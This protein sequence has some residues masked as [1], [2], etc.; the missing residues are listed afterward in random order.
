MGDVSLTLNQDKRRRFDSYPGSITAGQALLTLAGSARKAG[1]C[2]LGC[3]LVAEAE[4]PL[5]EPEGEREQVFR[6]GF[7]WVDRP[8]EQPQP[9]VEHEVAAA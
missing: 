9:E 5:P 7:G 6:K 4:V 1:D 8:V 3:A 2:T